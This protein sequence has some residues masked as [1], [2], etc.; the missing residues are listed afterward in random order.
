ME[1]LEEAQQGSPL[2]LKSLCFN[3]DTV[4][5]PTFPVILFVVS[6]FTVPKSYL[7]S[8]KTPFDEEDEA[9]STNGHSLGTDTCPSST[10]PDIPRAIFSHFQPG[11]SL[12]CDTAAEYIRVSLKSA[13]DRLGFGFCKSG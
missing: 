8:W 9:H 4:F 2:C 3:T 13:G 5:H 6:S 10:S 7:E 1:K 12:S 11:I